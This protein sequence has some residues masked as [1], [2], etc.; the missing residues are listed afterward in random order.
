MPLATMCRAK[1]KF[2]PLI[3]PMGETAD[4]QN[5]DSATMITAS[6]EGG[7][8]AELSP[9]W[10]IWG[11]QG[12]YLAAVALRAA[13]SEMGRA[14]PASMNAH[15][16]GAG[17]SGPVEVAV[18]TNRSTRVATSV[19]VTVAQESDRGMRTLLVATVWGVDDDLPGLAHQRAGLPLDPMSP[20]GVPSA[21]ERM[22]ASGATWPH[23]FW[24]NLESRPV[25][26]IDDWDNR[27]DQAPRELNWYRFVDGETFDDPWVDAGR[28]LVVLDVDAWGCAVRAN[29]GELEH[30]A[31][32]IEL[33]VRFIGDARGHR[34][35]LGDAES[36]VSSAGLVAHSGIVWTPDGAIVAT[37]GS[38]LLCRPAA[39]R[40]DSAIQ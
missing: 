4:M 22:A 30:F 2:K 34:W 5:L 14:R 3:D 23:P 37:G 15:F 32:T 18:E 21:E 38:T 40:P 26:W 27:K 31:P 11:P 6:R 28:V 25:L 19:T 17:T 13:G 9:S 12:G 29:E 10:E 8:T 39:R 35:L 16:V 36:P 7:Y 33:T 20:D 24:R 1:L